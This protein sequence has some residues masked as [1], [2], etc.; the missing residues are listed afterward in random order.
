MDN[1]SVFFFFSLQKPQIR[2]RRIRA[3]LVVIAKQFS[4]LQ[5]KLKGKENL[6]TLE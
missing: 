3:I 2:H 6:I 5:D 1:F 4:N